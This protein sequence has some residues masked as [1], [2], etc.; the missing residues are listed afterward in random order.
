MGDSP[1]FM[2]RTTAVYSFYSVL[3][4]IH[5]KRKDP[6]GQFVTFQISKNGIRLMYTNQ[7]KTLHAMTFLESGEQ[8][9]FS[10]YDVDEEKEISFMLRLDILLEC[11]AVFGINNLNSVSLRMAFNEAEATFHLM[12]EEKGV[13]TEC[14]LRTVEYDTE[15][16]IDF[17]GAYRESDEVVKIIMHSGPLR[18]I[19]SELAETPGMSHY[20][21]QASPQNKLNI[22][23]AGTTG[24]C[25]VEFDPTSQIFVAFEC[26]AE[27][28]AK[29]RS[30]LITH[31]SQAKALQKCSKVYVRINES[32]I[33]L[34]QHC[35]ELPE[36]N[37]D[38]TYVNFIVAAEY[39]EEEVV[40]D[41]T[42]MGEEDE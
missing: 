3:Q 31:A 13:M 6:E 35:L 42:M 7:A 14:T 38:E 9:L 23:T 18:E 21:I 37:G 24:E 29:Y 20:T 22:A 30:Q 11:L 36:L 27:V 19:F 1:P 5:S 4:A 15:D 33:L 39:E 2:C 16:E 25:V 40:D 32:K 12:L 8:S 17:H 10:E 41:E 34:L 28:V 26:S